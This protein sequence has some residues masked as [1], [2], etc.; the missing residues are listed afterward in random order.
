M[1]FG[2]DARSLHGGRWLRRSGSGG[3]LVDRVRSPPEEQARGHGG[4]GRGEGEDGAR[5]VVG[6]L[7]AQHAG[8]PPVLAR[9]LVAPRK[10]DHLRRRLAVL[11]FGRIGQATAR[12]AAAMGME[13]VAWSRSLTEDAAEAAGVALAPPPEEAARDA[14]ALPLPPPAPPET[15]GPRR[16]SARAALWRAAAGAGGESELGGWGRGAV[17]RGGG[18]WGSAKG[19]A[20]GSG[21]SK[22]GSSESGDAGS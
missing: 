18:K 17:G 1:G 3:H 19:G 2:L 20:V 21:G 9:L 5:V 14:D 13:V 10:R 8:R 22:L 6:G 7:A 15:T 16:A 4:G 11:G 12:I